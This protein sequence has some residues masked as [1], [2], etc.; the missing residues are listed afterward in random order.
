MEE[1]RKYYRNEWF[2]KN[3]PEFIL[4]G[5]SKREFGF[6]H[7]GHG[8][9][10]RY[11]V[12]K[13]KDSLRRF[14]RYKAPF[15][16]YISVAFYENPRRRG[17]WIKSEYIFDVDAKDLPIRSCNC[18]S[19]CEIC[20][21]EALEI[22]NNLIDTLEGDIGLNNIHLI[23]SGR[24]Y[25]IRI[26]NKEIMDS[27]SDLRSEVLKYVAG[28]EI[29]NLQYSN[30]EGGSGSSYNF[31]HFSIPIGYPKVFTDRIKYNIQ[32]LTGKESIDGIN[33]KLLKDIIKNRDFLE[34][35]QWGI[36]KSKIGPRRYKD[37]VKA[38]ARVNLATIDAKVT[39][40]LKRILRLPSS[41]HS[42][43]SMKCVEVKDRECFDPLKSAVPKFVEE[44]E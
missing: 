14:L 18:D 21:G 22:V 16:A 17:D 26:L 3:L 9:N 28:A 39:I 20:L 38:M 13:G 36:F 23:Y 2:D 31:E 7:L 10:D 8:P 43:V 30:L 35:N 4:D 27:D 24:G 5:L 42:K 11:K 1:R 34:D 40:D 15:A 29:P 44:R 12:F 25:H 37:M 19:V 32:H 41:L 33:P 6:D